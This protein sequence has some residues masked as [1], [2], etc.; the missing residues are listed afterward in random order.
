MMLTGA[1]RFGY[2]LVPAVS[3]S[4]RAY[5]RQPSHL[6]GNGLAL[7]MLERGDVDVVISHAP[8][9]EAAALASHPAW[10]YRKVMLNDLVLGDSAHR[11]PGVHGLPEAR[12]IV[13]R[14]HAATLMERVVRVE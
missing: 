10:R 6:V 9:A 2:V 13:R 11:V 3:L 8:A 1:M 7:R 5:G 4:P 12:R 14:P